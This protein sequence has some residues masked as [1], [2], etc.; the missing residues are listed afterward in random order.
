[1]LHS[2]RAENLT[3]CDSFE[4]EGAF[5]RQNTSLA[6]SILTHSIHNFN[7]LFLKCIRV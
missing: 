6:G 4:R 2:E 3:S 7:N 5:K 1:V